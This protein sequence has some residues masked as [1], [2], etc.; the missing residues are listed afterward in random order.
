MR[1]MAHAAL[2]EHGWLVSM[3]LRKILALM[4][5]ETAAF[6]NESTTP[7]QTVALRAW[8]ARNRRMLAKRLKGGGRIR[9]GKE[10]HFLFSALPQ[11]CQ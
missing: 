1:V 3:D 7:I 6:E 2:L 11:H 4:A 9:T 5:I 8:H 10:P